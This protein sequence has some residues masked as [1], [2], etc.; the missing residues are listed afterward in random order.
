MRKRFIDLVISTLCLLLLWP[1]FLVTAVVILLMDGRPIFY[2]QQRLGQHGQIITIRKFRSMTH[3]PHRQT[4]TQVRLDNPEVTRF[5]RFMRRTKIDELP[6]IWNVWVGDMSVV[7]PRPALPS[8]LENYTPR[9]RRRLEVKGGLTCLAQVFGG[10]Y[11]PWDER[12]E[13]DLEYIA[14]QSFWLDLRIILKTILVVL[15]GEERFIKRPR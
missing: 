8:N 10:S 13:Y 4:D 9:Q 7:G 2:C 5:G 14:R 15:M 11:L 1:A 3:N 6:Q 12:I